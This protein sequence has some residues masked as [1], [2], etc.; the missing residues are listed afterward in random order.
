MQEIM[1]YLRKYG[2]RL[3]SEIA[4]ATGIPLV[5][6]RRSIDDLSAR[7]EITKCKV[8]RFNG[9]EKMEGFLCRAAGI[10]APTSPGRKPGARPAG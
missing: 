3:D 7:G 8:T 5:K 10:I 1:Q 9:D 2:Q 6:V 4:E